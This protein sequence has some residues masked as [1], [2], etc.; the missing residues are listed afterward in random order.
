[1]VS[2]N[3]DHVKIR[4]A[5]SW[6]GKNP[7]YV[8]QSSFSGLNK[9]MA[10]VK[11]FFLVLDAQQETFGIRLSLQKPES[12]VLQGGMV[13]QVRKHC[14]GATIGDILKDESNG[15]LWLHLFSQ[16]QDWYIRLAKSRPPEMSL[17]NPDGVIVMRLGMKGT[18]T[19]KKDLGEIQLGK[20]PHVK[21]VKGAL[22]QEFL[23]ET[24]EVSGF[25]E[26]Q[27]H[28]KTDVSKEQRVLVQK[29]K[30]KLKTYRKSLL[31]LESQ[32]LSHH[33]MEDLAMKAGLLQS[34]GYLVK[35][36][37]F[38][39][40]LGEELTGGSSELVIDLD[41]ELSLGANIEQYFIKAKKA[42]KSCSMSSKLIQASQQDIAKLE[43]DLKYLETPRTVSEVEDLFGV[44]KLPRVQ[45]SNTKTKQAGGAKPF[46][47]FLSSTGHQILVGKGPRENDELTKSAKSNDYWLHTSAVAGSHVIIPMKKDLRD[48]LPGPL[49]KEGAILAI[50]YSK[51]RGDLAGEVYI[52]KR[53]EIK[54]QKG[55]APGLWNVERCQ[56][57]FFRYS[58]EELKGLLDRL[59]P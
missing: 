9:E 24:A 59:Q 27:D 46:R 21:S 28:D 43:D 54:K 5:K 40:V 19:K 39:L 55:M 53:S 10:T 20:D 22:I 45:E 26:A 2:I 51:L 35:E 12:L 13:N 18:F 50:H 1:M 52:A 58:K 44:Y 41:P 37:D 57:M 23:S 14:R 29:L 16:G 7:L 32:H 25:V 38:Q 17:I 34:F 3:Y 31:K 30:R 49:L 48:G 36:G 8:F 4:T 42:K 33:E 56:T 11:K 6:Q 15:N 47:V